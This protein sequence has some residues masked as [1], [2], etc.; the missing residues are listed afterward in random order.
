MPRPRRSKIE[1]I[2]DVLSALEPG[3]SNPTR[4]ATEANLAYDR[5]SKL[6]EELERRGLVRRGAGEVCMTR[7]GARFLSEYRRWRSF[8]DAFGL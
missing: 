2:A 7:E 6:L 3:C 5:L 1:I 8:L 4:L